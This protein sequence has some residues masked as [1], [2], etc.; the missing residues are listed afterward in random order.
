MVEELAFYTNG[1]DRKAAQAFSVLLR[2]FVARGGP[3]AALAANEPRWLARAS[4]GMATIWD[5]DR[6]YAELA[7]IYHAERSKRFRN[8]WVEGYKTALLNETV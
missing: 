7:H 8:V 2:D 4:L 6:S 1:P 3:A 5:F